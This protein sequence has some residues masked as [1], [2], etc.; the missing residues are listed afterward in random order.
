MKSCFLETVNNL[1][2]KYY[3]NHKLKT[4]IINN[5]NGVKSES[6]IDSIINS[7]LIIS[8]DSFPMYLAI[9]FNIKTFLI[10]GPT[11]PKQYIDNFQNDSLQ[12]Y[13][14][15]VETCRFCYRASDKGQSKM[16]TCQDP[17]CMKTINYK[18][19]I[20]DINSL[21]IK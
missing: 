8:V 13:N 21:L 7:D 15:N 12:I 20:K 10:V 3:L 19:V 9:S 1:F 5:L 16:Y 17:I 2:M 6:L 11:D 4:K 18:K 14:P